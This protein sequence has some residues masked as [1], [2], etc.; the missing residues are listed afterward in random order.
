MSLKVYIAA[1]GEDQ[2][3]AKLARTM[4]DVLG[5][6]STARWIDQSLVNE[7][8]D[9]AQM[10]IDDVRSADALILIK[11]KDSHRTTTG[12]PHVETGIALERGLPIVLLGEREN[13][14]HQH[15]GVRVLPWPIV[16]WSA[17]ADE[18]AIAVL[19]RAKA[20]GLEA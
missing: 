7:S 8:H 3:L 13:V 2:L 19:E 15:Q 11:P 9:E 4:L 14:F 20:K 18:I 10:D 16:S 17:V 12:G 5:I 6:Q 1:R